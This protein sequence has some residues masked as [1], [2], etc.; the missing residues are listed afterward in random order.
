MTVH[1]AKSL[2]RPIDVFGLKGRWLVIFLICAGVSI[3]VAL[4]LGSVISS[5]VGISAAIIAVVA[6]FMFCMVKQG[7]VSHRQ[8]SKAK[9]SS[10]IYSHVSRRETLGRILLPDPRMRE[11][12]ITIIKARD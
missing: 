7:T 10:A 2:D 5:G 6:S 8:V 4:I 11:D 9:A 3:V 1:F 12:G